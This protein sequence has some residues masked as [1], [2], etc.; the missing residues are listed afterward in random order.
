LYDSDEE[1][2]AL[3]HP[4][5]VLP[6]SRQTFVFSATLVAG[7]N[8]L[9]KKLTSDKPLK[10]QPTSTIDKLLQRLEMKDPVYISSLTSSLLASGLSE[11]RIDCLNEEKDAAL[12]YMLIRYPGRTVVFANSIDA[13]RRVVP[14][15]KMMGVEAHALHAEMQQRQ[16]LKNLDR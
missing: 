14:V 7:N 13:V 8:T 15:L 3:L 2:A 1:E 12:Y 5:Y 4:S 10:K 16:R 9:S 11:A 6:T